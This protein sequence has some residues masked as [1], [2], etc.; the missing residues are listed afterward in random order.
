MNFFVF[1]S[2]PHVSEDKQQVRKK[3]IFD[4]LWGGIQ[5]C[6]SKEGTVKRGMEYAESF[7]LIVLIKSEFDENTETPGKKD[8]FKLT[9]D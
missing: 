2:S 7:T 3:G 1:C 9:G 5:R 8:A 6:V 4:Y